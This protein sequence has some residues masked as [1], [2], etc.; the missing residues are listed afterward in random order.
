MSGGERTISNA[1]YELQVVEDSSDGFFS[2][3]KPSSRFY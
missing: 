3:V 2:I 1:E